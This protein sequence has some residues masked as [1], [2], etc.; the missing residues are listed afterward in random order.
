MRVP[1][2]AHARSNTHKGQSQLVS[3]YHIV[4]FLPG[5]MKVIGVIMLGTAYLNCH[6]IKTL[7]LTVVFGVFT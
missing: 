4:H 6:S 1:H 7:P 2:A 5:P 3:Y